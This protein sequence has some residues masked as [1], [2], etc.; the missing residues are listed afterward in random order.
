[1]IYR[2]FP[3]EKDL[4]ISHIITYYYFEFAKDYIFTGEKHDFWE[5]VYVDKGELEVMADE[6]GYR[7]N[8]G[9]CIFH[10]PDEFHSLWANGTIAP[11]IVIFSFMSPSKAMS[12]FEEKIMTFDAYQKELLDKALKEA[13]GT[14]SY[15]NDEKTSQAYLTL[16]EKALPGACQLVQTYLEELLIY[17]L[18]KDNGMKRTANI[19][20]SVKKRYDNDIVQ[21]II[22]YLQANLYKD[23][24]FSH[25]ANHFCL[26][27]TYIK[28]LFK[29][30]TGTSVMKFYKTLKIQEA[31]R[32]IR[33]SDK[34]FTEIAECL[35]YNSIHSFSRQFK[36]IMDMTPSQYQKSIM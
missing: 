36:L 26:S 17:S 12:F 11:N 34:S 14:F 27:S 23:L 30:K 7:L 28:S 4:S 18:R 15:K 20:A 5:M 22:E 31:K 6:T 3:F 33:E 29:E 32:L 13:T 21:M 19:S 16:N 9:Q 25:I 10:K 24:A 2:P 1:M 35:C 8:Q